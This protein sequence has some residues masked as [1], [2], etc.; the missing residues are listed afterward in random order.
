MTTPTA[1][2]GVRFPPPLIYLAGLAAGFALDQ[3][4]AL[5]F[6][7]HAGEAL[8][9]HPEPGL[10]LR[11]RHAFAAT[12]R[13]EPQRGPARRRAI[14]RQREHTVEVSVILAIVERRRIDLRIERA[15][16]QWCAL[17]VVTV[18]PVQ[19]VPHVPDRNAPRVRE[20]TSRGELS[21]DA[22]GTDK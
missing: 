21:R 8:L 19:R 4:V 20:R 15:T 2:P 7:E 12:D 18:V 16:G 5:Q 11:H 17:S 22:A 14:A 6:A 13:R 3:A 10:Q 9:A 1:N